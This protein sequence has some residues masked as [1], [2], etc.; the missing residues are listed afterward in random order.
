MK[1]YILISNTKEYLINKKLL[2]NISFQI[3][4]FADR[5][6]N[7]KELSIKQAYECDFFDTEINTE[8]KVSIKN[9]LL[10]KNIDC[11]F[12]MPTKYRKKKLLLADMDSTIIEE[13]SLDEI[14]K[15]IGI[16]KEIIK[17]TNEAMNGKIDFKL[18]LQ[19]RVAMLKG[20]PANLLNILKKNININEGAK[21]L[22]NTMKQNGATTVLVSGGFTFLTEHLKTLLGFNYTH[23]NSLEITTNKYK[24][25]I[26]TGKIQG[27]ILDNK[28]KLKYLNKYVKD[29]ELSYEDTICVGDGA[30]DVEMIKRACLGISFNGKKILDETANVQFKNTNLKGLLYL[31]GYC[32]AEIT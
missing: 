20:Q 11:N 15:Q 2:D 28:A 16:E 32:D 23:A 10:K 5:K 19:K 8:L 29:N 12:V 7:F 3:E 1:H 25:D 13:E 30:N 14:A 31:Q 21:E 17:I 6:I 18:A 9:F 26:L 22:I 24:S 27:I 4:K